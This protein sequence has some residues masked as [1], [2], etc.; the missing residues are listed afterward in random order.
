MSI[1]DL[2]LLHD[3]LAFHIERKNNFINNYLALWPNDPW[4]HQELKEINKLIVQTEIQIQEAIIAAARAN[5][6]PPTD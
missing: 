5:R 2:V 3:I 1:Y 4:V 6:P